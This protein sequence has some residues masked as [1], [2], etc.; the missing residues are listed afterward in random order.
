MKSCVYLTLVL[1]I[2]FTG[3]M[4][5][6]AASLN[7][8]SAFSCFNVAE[9]PLQECEALVVLYDST[10]GS[11]WTD[12]ANWLVTNTPSDWYGIT[13]TGGH[14]TNIYLYGNHLLGQLPTE[15][16]NLSGLLELNL[17]TNQLDGGIPPTLGNLHN[18][19]YLHLSDNMLY[20]KIPPELG[21]L[22]NLRELSL[23]WN[24]LY[25]GIPYEM[26]NLLSLTSLSIG[27]NYQLSGPLPSSLTN[28][29]LNYFF[30]SD[31]LLC[32]PGDADFQAWLGSIRDL[33]RTG[34]IC[35]GQFTSCDLVVEIPPSECQALLELYD[36]TNGTGWGNNT[37]WLQADQPSFW[38]GVAVTAGHV[39]GVNLPDNE[40][41]GYIPDNFGNLP[42]LTEL[43]LSN[44]QLRG[45]IPAELGNLSSLVTLD[46]GSN[47]LIG[48]IPPELGNLTNLIYLYLGDN[49]FSGSIPPELGS[50]ANLSHLGL[51]SNHLSGTIPPQLGDLV[52]LQSLGLS[53]NQLSGNIPPELGNLANLSQ[54]ALSHN[55]LAGS[56]PPELGKFTH[57]LFF[58]L[59][60]N[61]LSG[62]IPAELGKLASAWV[63][64]LSSNQLSGG[65]PAELG[66]LG[67]WNLYLNDNQLTGSIPATF[68]NLAA[69]MVVDL[70][71]NRLSGS[72]PPELGNLANLLGLD[73][74]HNQLSGSIPADLGKIIGIDSLELQDNRL[75]GDIPASFMNLAWLCE[76]PSCDRPGLD[77]DYNLLNV[78]PGYPDQNEEFQVFLY[79]KDPDWHLYQGFKQQVGAAGGEIRSLDGR[80]DILIPAGALITDTLFTYKPWS[81]PDHSKG[82]LGFAHNTFD[83][84]ATDTYS[85]PVTIFGSPITV[86]LSYT[87]TD[88]YGVPENTLALYF[89]DEPSGSW[90]DGVT[91]CAGGSYQV[92]LDGNQLRL[93][94]CHL[95]E[96]ALFGS[97]QR[98]LLPDIR[99][100]TLPVP[101]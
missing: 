68:G 50:L 44:N 9:I 4:P 61:Q 16:G 62:S 27:H 76:P 80:T 11:E 82:S 89:W 41:W 83:L 54:L 86:T 78:P 40:L 60:G 91:T 6:A 39:T 35:P 1:A 43:S 32:E 85:N 23:S 13:V 72:I 66:N 17:T 58:D 73:L 45:E 26:G 99:N 52:S 28:L 29:T 79:K 7:S 100:R 98:V 69:A 30:F 46:L 88:L 15:L 87:T 56:I 37:W 18:L 94:L 65:I 64:D 22:V 25:G 36:H 51:Y 19:L 12:N 96:F 57:I 47:Y 90:K 63:I 93:P 74:S 77:L 67:V 97:P 10:R 24:E 33:W 81:I 3:I 48:D 59:G 31:T 20:G 21:N 55:Y 42:N 5:S 8:A 95:T 84:T 71:H 49:Q 53:D 14:V 34:V 75:D 92:D 2:I 70:S 38:Y 101:P